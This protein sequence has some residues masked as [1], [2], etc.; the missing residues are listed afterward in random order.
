MSR[1][2]SSYPGYRTGWR[3]EKYLDV[4]VVPALITIVTGPWYFIGFMLANYFEDYLIGGILYYTTSSLL[5]AFLIIAVFV[6]GVTAFDISRKSETTEIS[7]RT[8]RT[9]KGRVSSPGRSIE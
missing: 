1:K 9:R 7:D 2:G 5:I 6:I 3:L 8:D 4:C